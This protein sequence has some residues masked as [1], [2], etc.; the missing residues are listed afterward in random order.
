MQSYQ[1][2]IFLSY[3][4]QDQ[5]KVDEIYLKL[6]H[7][8]FT[9]WMDTKDLLPGED[10]KRVVI[11]TIREAPFFLACISNSSINKRGVVQEELKEAL[12]VWRQKLDDDIYFIP[13]RLEKCEVPEPLA[14][15]Q[16][17]DLF[18]SN[19]FEKL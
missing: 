16:W 19:G 17:V 7:N 9:P 11:K 8:G 15:F 13:I 12:E 3:A 4:R 5:A 14:K 2:K 10:W 18:E 1:A 6:L